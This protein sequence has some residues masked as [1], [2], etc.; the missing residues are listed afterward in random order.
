M[1]LTKYIVTLLSLILATASLS[2]NKHDLNRDKQISWE[3]F[4]MVK[5]KQAAQNGKEYNAK[6][7]RF[8]FEDKDHDGNGALSY[9]EF[10]NHPVDL[11][12]DKSI[13]YEEFSAM[14]KRRAERNGRT[15][16]DAWIKNMF[17]K[18]DGNGNGEL[19]YKELAKPVK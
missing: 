4:E 17:D 9:K 15:A 1:K 19:S 10:N 8:L 14:H 16:K 2:A 18:K 13:S 7:T 3:E 5:K 6:H 12:G 11:D